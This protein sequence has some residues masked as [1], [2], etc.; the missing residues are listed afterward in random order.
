MSKIVYLQN[1]DRKTFTRKQM[2]M[3]INLFWLLTN[4]SILLLIFY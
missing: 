3:I 2:N 4:V 1:F